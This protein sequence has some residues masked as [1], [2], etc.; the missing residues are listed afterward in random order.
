MAPVKV[1]ALKSSYFGEVKPYNG[2][3]YQQLVIDSFL[4]NQITMVRGPAGAGKTL[5]Q[6]GFMFSLLE[7]HKIDKIVI[8]CNTPKTANSVGLGLTDRAPSLGNWRVQIS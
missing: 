3:V 8:F 4:N 5:L 2:D 6:M 1:K 7:K